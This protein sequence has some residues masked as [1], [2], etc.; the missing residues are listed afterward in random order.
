MR[1]GKLLKNQGYGFITVVC[2]ILALSSLAMLAF[3]NQ[4]DSENLT[5]AV[6]DFTQTRS[7]IDQMGVAVH[8]LYSAESTCG[9]SVIQ[10]DSGYTRAY[11]R[12]LLEVADIL[13][14]ISRARDGAA[15]GTDMEHLVTDTVQSRHAYI[16]AR[17]LLD[18]LM[19]LSRYSGASRP[20]VMT[21]ANT[22]V[23]QA[24]YGASLEENEQALLTASQ[25]LLQG[26]Q[27]TLISLKA[28]ISAQQAQRKQRLVST[29]EGIKFANILLI[30]F[31]LLVTLILIWIL[32]KLFANRKALKRAKEAAEEFAD[33][34]N[35]F[36][37]TIKQPQG[38]AALKEA[39][40]PL[41]LVVDNDLLNRAY[42][43]MLLRKKGFSVTEAESGKK[44]LA[45][46]RQ[47]VFDL[48]IT[49]ISMPEMSGYQFAAAIRAFPGPEHQVPVL[50]ISGNLPARNERDGPALINFNAWLQ[51][52]FQP[53]ELYEIVARCVT[54]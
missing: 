4:R 32:Q 9:L 24:I 54:G 50:G 17:L 27:T 20:V 21:S 19:Q 52:P 29:A 5:K 53:K 28:S 51:K 35:E 1:K 49:D 8:L 33:L 30:V 2:L 14:A 45:A 11:Q 16:Y 23:K 41:V 12:Q 38:D 44:G 48:V 36:A 47:Q 7:S 15:D 13:D 3:L 40:G 25:H 39:H 34:N 37:E 10:K 43:A 6:E 42:V 46:F 18:S 26:L 31:G 22:P